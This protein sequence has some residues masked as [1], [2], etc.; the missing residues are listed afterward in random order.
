[1]GCRKLGCP[2]ARSCDG[3]PEAPEPRGLICDDCG[4]IIRAGEIYWSFSTCALCDSCVIG[5]GAMELAKRLR[6]I[7]SGALPPIPGFARDCPRRSA[8]SQQ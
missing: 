6:Y 8:A 5:M 4:E 2:G 3:C 1:M 7:S